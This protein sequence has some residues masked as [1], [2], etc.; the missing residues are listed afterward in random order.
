VGLD[1]GLKD[2]DLVTVHLME[3]IFSRQRLEFVRALIE[4]IVVLDECTVKA[5]E[6]L[7]RDIREPYA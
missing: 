2:C 5:A 4:R 1:L 7:I 6:R 3:N